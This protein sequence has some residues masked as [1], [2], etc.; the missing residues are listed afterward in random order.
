MLFTISSLYSRRNSLIVFH[1]CVD[2]TIV[3]TNGNT[4]KP[5]ILPTA[6]KTIDHVT[7]TFSDSKSPLSIGNH[8]S[9]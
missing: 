3:P 5:T 6:W 1:P 9:T 2:N 7:V 4:T 8:C